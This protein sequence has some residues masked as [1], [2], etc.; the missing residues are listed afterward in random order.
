[1]QYYSIFLLTY[2]VKMPDFSLEAKF[3][4]LVAGID[5]AGRG[6]LAGPVVAAAVIF[7]SYNCDYANQ[8]QDSK[9]I[10]ARKRVEL[11]DKLISDQ[12]ICYNYAIINEEEID[13]LNIF[14]AT[15]KAMEMAVAKLA[16]EASYFLID[17]KFK[18][19]TK[20]NSYPVI[21]GDNISNSIAAASIIAKVVRDQIMHD[22]A[23]KYPQYD[24]QNNA[25]YGTKK[26]LAA[27]EK[28]GITKFHRKSFAPIKNN[29][30]NYK[31]FTQKIL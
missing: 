25:G 13:K 9:K 15:K 10:T 30:H 23:T 2:L 1:M 21:K 5:E 19:I 17:G 31:L 18:M 6:P 8:L 4:D 20:T 14:N 29:L 16:C 11:Y 3:N 26:H 7:L 24:W 28:Y 27:I 22:L 12:N